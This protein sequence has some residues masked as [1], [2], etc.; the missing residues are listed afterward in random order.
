[1]THEIQSSTTH[2]AVQLLADHGFDSMAQAI[3]IRSERQDQGDA[4]NACRFDF[5][6]VY[7]CG[8]DTYM[9]VE[10]GVS[11]DSVKRI[12]THGGR[13]CDQGVSPD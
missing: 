7:A 2:E 9:A 3:R 11:R 10:V 12:A 6:S 13:T 8:H 4:K 1:M 5:V